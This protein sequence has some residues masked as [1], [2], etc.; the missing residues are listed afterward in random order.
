M[1]SKETARNKF[2]DS[3]PTPRD[4]QGDAH[5]QSGKKHGTKVKAKQN[6][7][8][9]PANIE[10]FAHGGSIQCMLLLKKTEDSNLP[11]EQRLVSGGSDGYVKLWA[12]G[13]PNQRISCKV[14]LRNSRLPVYSMSL[15]GD[16]LYCGLECG[17][18]NVF[19]VESRQLVYSLSTGNGAVLAI[20]VINGSAFCGTSNGRVRVGRNIPIQRHRVDIDSTL[21]RVSLDWIAGFRTRGRSWLRQ[22][23]DSVLERPLSPEEMTIAS[24]SGMS[25]PLSNHQSNGHPQ[26][27]SS[28][29]RVDK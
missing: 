20:R 19:N 2:F 4:V 21:T 6:S 29:P 26:M 22:L 3:A 17:Y 14:K 27:V 23:V 28:R 1:P 11:G 7:W 16:L 24:T 5:S 13:D 10:R 9:Q 8:F 15:S 25:A 18:I 12:L